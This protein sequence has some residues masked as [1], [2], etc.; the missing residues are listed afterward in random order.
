MLFNEWN[1]RK[2]IWINELTLIFIVIIV[3]NIVHITDIFSQN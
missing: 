3:K 2:D 1:K